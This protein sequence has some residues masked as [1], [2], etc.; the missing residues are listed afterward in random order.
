MP[1]LTLI[2]TGE[3]VWVPQDSLQSALDTGAYV[4]DPTMRLTTVDD[5]GGVGSVAYGDLGRAHGTF[6]AGLAT[7]NT[8]NTG[9]LK[10]HRE[11]T[12]GTVGQ[13]IIT[14]AEGLARGASFGLSDMAL[15][16]LGIS[17]P[18][19]MKA[20]REVNPTIATT[21]EITGAV[22]PALLSGGT[23]A[24]VSATKLGV[25]AA[26]AASTAKKVLSATPAAQAA[27]LG[28]SIAGKGTGKG[29]AAR[30]VAGGVSG[31]VEG[32]LYGTGQGISELAMSDKPL[33][34]ERI[35]STLGSGALTGAAYGGAIGGVLPVLGTAYSKSKSLLAKGKDSGAI[36]TVWNKVIGDSVP[37]TEAKL[38][39]IKNSMEST[40]E[41]ADSLYGNMKVE[42]LEKRALINAEHNLIRNPASI[43]KVSLIDD[44]LSNFDLAQKKYR[45]SLTTMFSK[46]EGFRNSRI[47]N[48]LMKASDD[49]LNRSLLVIK[50]FQDAGD[51]LLNTYNKVSSAAEGVRGV[52][53]GGALPDRLPTTIKSKLDELKGVEKK[54]A[55]WEIGDYSIFAGA[56]GLSVVDIPIV[57]D[58][59]YLQELLLLRTG[60][61]FVNGIRMKSM[62][63]TLKNTTPEVTNTLLAAQAATT[64]A[65]KTD[66]GIKSFLQASGNAA[67]KVKVSPIP[68]ALAIF[69]NASYTSG[70]EKSY[71]LK[72]TRE[73]F[74]KR[75][76]ELEQLGVNPDVMGDNIKVSLGPVPPDI[77]DAVLKVQQ[78][79]VKFL[80][81][82]LP[83][84]PTG[85]RLIEKEWKPSTLEMRKFSR[86]L[87]AVEEPLT[88]IDDM[89]QGRLSR[90]AV[91]AMRT[92]YPE[93]FASI[94]A[95]ILEGIPELK[96]NMGYRARIQLS[97]LMD[98]PVDESMEPEFINL[99]QEDFKPDEKK[100]SGK[101]FD[102]PAMDGPMSDN[103]SSKKPGE[104]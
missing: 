47:V 60:Y 33:S 103:L 50:E 81:S 67:K 77:S 94:Q 27:K 99:M 17:D 39:K 98:V 66:K 12:F 56:L 72:D 31:A 19:A 40:M 5:R 68:P 8:V 7:Q 87:R 64:T 89:K 51:D 25:R 104:F 95:Q 43:E 4:V 29:L 79:K 32:G 75:A 63:N 86:Y 88:L 91:E 62:Y 102:I 61:K 78:A 101:G 44:A 22:A 100:K 73:A 14:G 53:G 57:S 26:K 49:E 59:P 48:D 93:M 71:S 37:K 2:E 52:P 13:E 20:R 35:V 54:S 97:R 46:E 38:S 1:K 90:E 18:E 15:T 10:Q 23:S 9:R 3:E 24:G 55:K 16:G 76:K 34:A 82:K 36:D 65:T 45:D 80:N 28:L 21:S 83:K 42:L 85:T 70:R 30:A 96:I 6:G 69:N 92:V 41:S 74:K 11:D 84:D 58:I